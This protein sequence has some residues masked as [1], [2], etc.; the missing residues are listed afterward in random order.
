MGVLENTS[1]RVLDEYKTDVAI[2][3]D[4]ATS[5]LIGNRGI[6]DFKSL[7]ETTGIKGGLLEGSRENGFFVSNLLR[8]QLNPT[9]TGVRPEVK[10]KIEGINFSEISNTLLLGTPYAYKERPLINK[11]NQMLGEIDFMG[12]VKTHDENFI[13]KD[14]GEKWTVETKQRTSGIIDTLVK[15]FKDR[16]S[17]KDFNIRINSYGEKE[18]GRKTPYTAS[19]TS[20]GDSVEIFETGFTKPSS[21]LEKTQNLFYSGTI[22]TMIN[23]F[24]I[25]DDGKVISRGRNLKRAGDPDKDASYENPFCRTW[26]KLHQYSRMKDRIRP[27]DKD[28][29]LSTKWENLRSVNGGT[30]LVNNSVLGKQGLVKITP[31]ESLR[32]KENLKKYMFSIEN[33]AWKDVNIN[34]ELSEEQRGPYGGRIMWFP[35][36]NLKFTENINV[37]WNSNKFIGRGEQIHTYVNTDRS[38]TLSFTLLIDHP[39]I[40]NKINDSLA[41]NEPNEID[42]EILRFFAGCY[43]FDTLPSDKNKTA[44]TV[45]KKEEKSSNQNPV[46][47]N[48]TEEK[49][50]LLFFPNNFSAIDIVKKNNAKAE[51]IISSFREYEYD[52][53]GNEEELSD[54]EYEKDKLLEEN[55]KDKNLYSLN[56]IKDA[57]EETLDQVKSLLGVT[58]SGETN[59]FSLLQIKKED[60][61][62]LTNNIETIKIE[63]HASSDGSSLKANQDL[64]IN[65]AKIAKKILQD[66]FNIEEDKFDNEYSKN[67]SGM[68][69]NS[70]TKKINA[71]KAKVAR[72]AV[73]KVIM[74][75]NTAPSDPQ[76]GE[77]DGRAKKTTGEEIVSIN[78]ENITNKNNNNSQYISSVKYEQTPSGYS[79]DNEYMFFKEM[80]EDGI[81][82]KNITSKVKYFSPA[83]HSITPEGFN[84]R[85]TF[86]NQCTRQGPTASASSGLVKKDDNGYL[87]YAGNLAFGRAPYCILRIGDFFY[88]K[89]CIDSISI[90]YN[91][92][93]GIQ[94]DLNPEGVGVQ[95][96]MANINMNFK[97]LGGQDLSGPIERLQ[98][99]VTSNYYANT[100][101]YSKHAD[102]NETF[103]EPL[104]DENAY[105]TKINDKNSK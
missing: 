58:V 42:E 24:K 39:S 53:S 66:Y 69:Q 54:K 34:K 43:D 14:K 61:K 46:L 72:S 20:I 8:N 29:R 40:L 76:L 62:L 19:T 74:K 55:K 9:Y 105:K 94:W 81:Y 28:I 7:I 35:P 15:E 6:T 33:L 10:E 47:K 75:K 71:L 13:E 56:K 104:L 50:F 26:T 17:S 95:P 65:R 52:K 98:N 18:E 5:L 57:D 93:D 1:Y 78:N 96:M 68:I 103:Y 102:N 60:I 80:S 11:Q 82:L 12:F 48:N 63:G 30:Y 73:I 51:D 25:D 37:E 84:A 91:N 99:A 23:R 32:D 86:L 36:Y 64:S 83:Y 4:I 89:I 49:Y 100:S 92:G 70:G 41:S 59:V 31:K 88:T 3:K 45:S 85:L 27:F 87:K 2:Q 16:F 22:N 67:H 97:F 90:D 44:E 77:H 21:L 101:V 79:Y 38:G